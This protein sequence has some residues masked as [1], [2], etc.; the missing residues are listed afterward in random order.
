MCYGNL[1]PKNYVLRNKFYAPIK[2]KVLNADSKK[3]C[4]RIRKTIGLTINIDSLAFDTF[5]FTC[6]EL[7]SISFFVGINRRSKEFS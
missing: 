6:V 2:L 5:I 3:I 1:L 7:S 4:T